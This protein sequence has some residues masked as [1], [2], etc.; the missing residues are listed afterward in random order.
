M[1]VLKNSSRRKP[2]TSLIYFKYF[3]HMATEVLMLKSVFIDHVVK[4]FKAT[5][6]H[7]IKLLSDTL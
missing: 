2:H 3:M 7:R 6:D 4:F 1:V 5:Y